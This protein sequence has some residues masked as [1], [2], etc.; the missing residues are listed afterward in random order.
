MFEVQKDDTC[1]KLLKGVLKNW[2]R[3]G[4]ARRAGLRGALIKH[5]EHVCT[6]GFAALDLKENTPGADAVRYVTMIADVK[7]CEVERRGY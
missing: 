2:R 3:G 1:L 6:T 7:S 4:E 5:C